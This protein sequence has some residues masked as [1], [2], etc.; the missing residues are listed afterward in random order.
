[1][2]LTAK[3]AAIPAAFVDIAYKPCIWL[4]IPPNPFL[5]KVSCVYKTQT[6]PVTVKS[7]LKIEIT[8]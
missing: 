5:V 4:E 3:V 6:A 7:L 1:M 2:T 8:F